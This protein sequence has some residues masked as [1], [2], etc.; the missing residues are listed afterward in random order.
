M[1]CFECVDIQQRPNRWDHFWP[2]DMSFRTWMIH[3]LAHSA[4]EF[5]RFIVCRIGILDAD[6]DGGLIFWRWD[7]WNGTMRA[8]HLELAGSLRQS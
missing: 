1:I 3:R 5:L 2:V 4:P 6:Y 7:F 8:L